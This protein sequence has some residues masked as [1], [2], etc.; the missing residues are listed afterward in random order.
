MIE[1]SFYY[2]LLTPEQRIV[3]AIDIERQQ[4][5]VLESFAQ[6]LRDMV[7]VGDDEN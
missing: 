7:D 5:E 2:D 6:R 3:I 4:L 1:P